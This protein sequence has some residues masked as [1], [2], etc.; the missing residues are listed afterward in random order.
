MVVGLVDGLIDGL[1]VGVGLAVGLAEG[2]AEGLADGLT[3]GLLEGLMDGLVE[4]LSVGLVEGLID[5]LPVGLVEGV[6]E[7]LA[8]GLVEGLAVGRVVGLV[9]GLAVGLMEIVLS[10]R[11][12]GWNYRQT[13]LRK[14]GTTS[15]VWRGLAAAVAAFLEAANQLH[16]TRA[17]TIPAPTAAAMSSVWSAS[18]SST[19][20]LATTVCAQSTHTVRF[21]AT[22]WLE[23]GA[24]RVVDAFGAT[25]PR[26]QSSQ[27][28]PPEAAW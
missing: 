6:A 10:S 28:A 20:A 7:G 18:P 2:L 22:V 25:E 1:S 14:D 11:V 15:G 21:T 8:V 5:G 9:E 24:Q 16:Q 27:T 17:A 12:E 13:V 4:G 3:V 26:A 23:H 19:Q